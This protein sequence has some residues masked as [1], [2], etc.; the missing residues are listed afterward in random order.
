MWIEPDWPAPAN[1]RALCTTRHG[2]VS[3]EPFASLN[4]ADHVGDDP[5][6]VAR[7]RAILRERTAIPADPIWLR[8]VHG[9]RVTDAA[10]NGADREADAAFTDSAGIVCAVLTADCLPLLLCDR[11]G[12]RI[13]A[14]HA[15]WRGLAAGVIEAAIDRF[16]VDPGGLLAWMGPAIGPRAFVVGGEV[17][18]RFLHQD[19]AAAAAFEPAQ[20]DR[21][22]ADLYALARRRLALRGV[23]AVW[24]GRLCTHADPGRFFSYRRDGRCGRI[25][26]LIW[27]TGGD[28]AREPVGP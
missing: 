6:A 2:G 8:Q 27:L 9:T 15:G 1:V 7:N 23:R 26:T 14:V 13:A 24:G 18:E 10:K 3:T 17:R 19:P 16:P 11:S 20:A 5:D 28:R 25:A 22:H 12:L 4:L 21:W